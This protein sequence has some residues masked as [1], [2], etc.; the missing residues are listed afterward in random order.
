VPP[1]RGPSQQPVVQ[2]WRRSRTQPKIE[3]AVLEGCVDRSNLDLD[4][5]GL[6][7]SWQNPDGKR[8]PPLHRE[9][10][11]AGDQ[12]SAASITVST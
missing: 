11:R 7:V 10:T 3:P 5:P 6:V 12:A 1:F 2:V 9:A 8:I 4:R